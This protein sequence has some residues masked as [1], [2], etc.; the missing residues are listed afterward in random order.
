MESE[1]PASSRR[2]RTKEQVTALIRSGPPLTRADL[3]Q[4]T[5][6]SRSAVAAVVQE[7]LDEGVI[8]EHMLPPGGRGAARPPCQGWC[9]CPARRP[10][11]CRPATARA[12]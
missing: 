12:A 4:A 1:Q 11:R 7:L 2:H 3:G 5:G 10:R 9:W 8:E 6:L